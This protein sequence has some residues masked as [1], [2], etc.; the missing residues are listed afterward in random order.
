LRPDATELKTLLASAGVAAETDTVLLG[1]V[2]RLAPAD[3]VP[4]LAALKEA[5]FESLMDFDGMDTGEAIE[6][7]WRVRS[8]SADAEVYLKTTVAYDAEIASAWNVYPSAL[9]PERETAELLGLRLAGHP[10]PKRLLTTDGIE[11]LLRKSV[12]VRTEEEVRRP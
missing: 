11:P 7:T 4:A 10:N 9:M 12:P 5:G 3:A 2:A 1:D 6:L 8:Y